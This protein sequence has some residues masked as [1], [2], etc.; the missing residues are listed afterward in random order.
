MCIRDRIKTWLKDPNTIL[1]YEGQ[2]LAERHLA[3]QVTLISVQNEAV[4]IQMDVQTH[5]PLRR[6]FQWRDPVFKDMNTDAEDYDNYHT[7]D[8]FPTPFTITRYKNDDMTRQYF[9]LHVAYNQS[10][11]P[12]FWSVDAAERRIKK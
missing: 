1:I 5:L 3:E 9:L 8:G 11:D 12:D 2:R 10:L 6:T 7:I 4:T